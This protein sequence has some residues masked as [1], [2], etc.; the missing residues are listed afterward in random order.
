MMQLIKMWFCAEHG[1]FLSEAAYEAHLFSAHWWIGP[2]PHY[3]QVART[4]SM[5]TGAEP[6]APSEE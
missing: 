6:P 4:I 5:R 3:I 2:R 1:E